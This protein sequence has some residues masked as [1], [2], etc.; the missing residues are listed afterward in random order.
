MLTVADE[1]RLRDAVGLL[2]AIEQGTHGAS[3]PDVTV[4]AMLTEGD[5]Y[6]CQDLVAVYGYSVSARAWLERVSEDQAIG[7]VLWFLYSAPLLF[8]F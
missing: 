7:R 8:G 4:Q 2:Q 1:K 3:R 6:Y 5:L